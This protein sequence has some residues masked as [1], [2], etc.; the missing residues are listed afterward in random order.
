MW[1]LWMLIGDTQGGSY[2]SVKK[3]S[4]VLRGQ[5]SE[6]LNRTILVYWF[7]QI[8]DLTPWTSFCIRLWPW[9]VYM[10]KTRTH[11]FNSPSRM[12]SWTHYPQ[13]ANKASGHPSLTWPIPQETNQ[14][15][16]NLTT[17]AN[18]ILLDNLQV[19][20]Q[21]LRFHRKSNSRWL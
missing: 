19:C 18:Q 1:N 20:L 21:H 8:A 6:A 11:I 16:Q 17:I 9:R 4:T 14:N 7:C 13:G 12:S 5:A 3:F 15:N 2:S 10:P